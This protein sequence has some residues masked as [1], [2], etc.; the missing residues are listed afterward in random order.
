[1]LTEGEA[2]THVQAAQKNKVP[3]ISYLVA[4]NLLIAKL[5]HQKLQLN[6]ACL[7]SIW[8]LLTAAPSLQKLVSEKLIRKHHAL[9][10][11]TRGSTLFVAI[12]DPTNFQALDDF[13]FHSRLNPEPSW[14][15]KTSSSKPLKYL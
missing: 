1:L 10:L 9:P 8:M 3:F 12:S 13:K 4:T 2:Q 15:M 7:F 14:L 11:F 5:L 6:L